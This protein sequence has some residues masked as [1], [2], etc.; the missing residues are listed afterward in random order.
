MYSNEGP[1]MVDPSVFTAIGSVMVVLKLLELVPAALSHPL[2][3]MVWPRGM[4]NAFA[5]T[6]GSVTE[7]GSFPPG[8]RP[9]VAQVLLPRLGGSY[10]TLCAPRFRWIGLRI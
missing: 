2:Q 5:K 6:S 7:P 10:I 9:K 1:V 3:T 4:K 8:K